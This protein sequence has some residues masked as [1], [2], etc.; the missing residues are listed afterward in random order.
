[1]NDGKKS[2]AEKIVYDALALVSE[3]SGKPPLE[4]LDGAVKSV[5]PVLEV[6]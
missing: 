5:T 1:M 4:V 6:R 3:R 2:V